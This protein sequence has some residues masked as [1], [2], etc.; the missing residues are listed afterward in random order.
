MKSMTILKVSPGQ[1]PEVIDLP[2]SLEEMQKL[3]GGSIEAIYPF[4]DMVAIVCNEEGKLVGE[5]PCRAIRD[6]DTGEILDIICG[7]F[8]V[9]GLTYDDFSS[10]SADQMNYYAQLF[11]YPE[12]FLWNGNHLVVLQMEMV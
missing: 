12:T 9:C 3:V 6:P 5:R 2:H 4:E 8:F 10:L 7:T 1:L 11:K